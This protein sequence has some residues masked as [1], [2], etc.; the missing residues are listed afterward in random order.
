MACFF[1]IWYFFE[2]CCVNR[3]V[4]LLSVLSSVSLF[5]YEL[6]NSA[7]LLCS[8]FCH[9]WLQN[10]FV[11][12]LMLCFRT[13]SPYLLVEF[14]SLFC[15][16]LFCVHCIIQSWYLFIFLLS[17]V[18]SCF[19]PR[20]VLH[21]FTSAA[22]YFLSQYLPAFFHWL[23]IFVCRCWFI[24]CIVSRFSHPG[25]EFLLV[26]STGTPIFSPSNFTPT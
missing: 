5:S 25:F 12:R 6:I 22:F 21:F 18:P 16:V 3:G 11:S 26:F 24:I 17:S 23:I 2:Y 8:L 13:F 20:V 4:F 19:F 1:P 9:I 15:N 7:F 10:S 14:F